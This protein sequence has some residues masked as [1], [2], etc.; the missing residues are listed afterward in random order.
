MLGLDAIKDLDVCIAGKTLTVS[1]V[2]TDREFQT[3]RGV[4]TEDQLPESVPFPEGPW[5]KLGLD[6]V[7][8]FEKAPPNTRFAISLIDYHSKWPK[9]GF[10][11]KVTSQSVIAFLTAM[12]SR[13]EFPLEIVTDD[14][15]Q[16]MPKEFQ[17]FLEER[18]ITHCLSSVY[19]PQANVD[20]ER[21]NPVLK[22]AVQKAVVKKESIKENVLKLLA[23]YRATTHATTG[24]K[25]CKLLH[26]RD[27]RTKL[28]IASFQK[29]QKEVDLE[30][31][32]EKVKYKQNADKCKN[33]KK[34]VLKPGDLVKLRKP[35][36][37]GKGDPQ[38]T[39]PNKVVQ[40]VRP[41][42]YMLADGT[43][44]NQSKLS[45]VRIDQ[46]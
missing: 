41:G 4:E 16:F 26:G 44:F 6:I 17:C 38:Y 20:V 11:E 27:M 40:V 14:G 21:W 24:E 46:E 25:P 12:F 18:K 13:E 36:A 39:P 2:E 37:V 30:K 19:Y 45:P 33:V 32:R 22:N 8:P 28:D 29:K 35:Q 9:V 7:G 1:E 31:V 15:P 34:P 5:E 3:S 43:I 10:V 42:T 23:C